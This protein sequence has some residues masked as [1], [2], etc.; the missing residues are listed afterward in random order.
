MKKTKITVFDRENKEAF[1]RGMRHGIPIGLGYLAV[2]FSLGIAAQQAGL[3]PLQSLLASLLCHASA[4]EYAGF[5]LIAANASYLAMAIMTFVANARYLLMSCA[6]SQRIDKDMPLCHRIGIGF[7]LT[8]EIFGIAIARQGRIN[9]FYSYG[10]FSVASPGWAIGTVLG[11]VAGNVL[12]ARLV[13]ALSVALFGMF[14]AVIIPPARR[15]KVI[16]GVVITCFFCSGGASVLPYISQ[17]SE[18]M[19]TIL[20]TIILASGAALLFPREEEKEDEQ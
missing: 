11:A 14:L 16:T 4:G 2:A 3:S 18:G 15:D 12:P 7:G 13:S 1:Q 5:T 8:D 17:L 9:P 10:A 19:R 6:M 20:L